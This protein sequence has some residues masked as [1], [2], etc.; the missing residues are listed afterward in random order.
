MKIFTLKDDRRNSPS[1][2]E[3]RQ[4]LLLIYEV[5]HAALQRKDEETVRNCQI[6]ITSLNDRLLTHD[7]EHTDRVKALMDNMFQ[8]QDEPTGEQTSSQYD[9]VWRKAFEV[10]DKAV[11][12]LYGKN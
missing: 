6:I 9:P 11:D 5:R 2:Q 3:D 8:S 1:F 7:Y 12:D 10:W 4:F